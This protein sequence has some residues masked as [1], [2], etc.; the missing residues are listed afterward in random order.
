[1][2]ETDIEII[3]KLGLHA[4]AAAKLVSVAAQFQS[5]IRVGRG[6]RLID[7]KSIMSLL[8]LGAGK[9]TTLHMIIDGCDEAAAHAAVTALINN[10]FD[11]AE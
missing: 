2:I 6:D 9:G 5:S 7:A 10:R 1:M 3:N 11:E 8:M 4:R